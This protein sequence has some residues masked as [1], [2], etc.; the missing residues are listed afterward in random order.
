VL[1]RPG[2]KEH[3]KHKKEALDDDGGNIP[4]RASDRFRIGELIGL[5]G[6]CKSIET[7][8]ICMEADLGTN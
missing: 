6:I 3:S 2:P 7:S 8:Q 5:I 4:L 1:W